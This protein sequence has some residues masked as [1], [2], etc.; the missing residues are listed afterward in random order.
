MFRIFF[1]LVLL[2]EVAKLFYFRHLFLDPIPYI[3]EAELSFSLVLLGWLGVLLFLLIGFFTRTAAIIN[4]VLVLVFFSSFTTIKYHFDAAL[5]GL[6]FMLMILPVARTF[7]I[8]SY[9]Y[10]L[11]LPQEEAQQVRRI[12]YFLPVLLVLCLQYLDSFFHKA[13]SEMW[14]KGLGVWLPAS[15]PNHIYNTHA[16][17][18]NQQ[19]AI[20]GIG[21]LVMLFELSFV[22]LLPFRKIRPWLIMIG[23]SMHIGIAFTFPI[24]SFGFTFAGIY[25]LLL[26]ASF[27]AGL[28][29]KI[30]RAS[31]SFAFLTAFRNSYISKMLPERGQSE[32]DA[33]QFISVAREQVKVKLLYCFTFYLVFAQLIK[34]LNAPLVIQA[35]EGIGLS[36]IH[37]YTQMAF[38]PL[39]VINA[40]MLGVTENL[41]Y[42]GFE[43]GSYQ[44]L[45]LEYAAPNGQAVWLPITDKQGMAS[46]YSFGRMFTKWSRTMGAFP[47]DTTQVKDGVVRFSSFWAAKNKVPLQQA[48]FRVL[49][50]E[51]TV[52]FNWEQD[53]LQQQMSKPWREVGILTWQNNQPRLLLHAPQ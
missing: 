32:R 21:Y 17:L 50:K 1:S 37:S 9:L 41:I 23:V 52:Q 45:A 3:A 5:V 10:R 27:W 13:A 11:R 25:M 36:K 28:H 6:S 18:L 30:R 8:D 38:L 46:T 14:L 34:L 26:P 24:P 12:Y 16:W 19:E 33:S 53:Y 4:Y 44:I 7:S 39:E 2:V 47:E 48:T 42:S 20:M 15:L 51:A 49:A 35:S 43:E 29:R 40:K 22:F 31:A